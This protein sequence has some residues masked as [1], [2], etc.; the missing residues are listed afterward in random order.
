MQPP[1]LIISLA[2]SF[3]RTGYFRSSEMPVCLPSCLLVDDAIAQQASVSSDES[4]FSGEE[5]EDQ[6]RCQP[7]CRPSRRGEHRGAA[8]VPLRIS[9]VHL[10]R[11]LF[12]YL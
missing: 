5:L 2:C 1:I 7:C 8:A 12:I 10:A 4:A 9:P 11:H 6:V 3:Y